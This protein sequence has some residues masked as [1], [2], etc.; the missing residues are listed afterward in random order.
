V[1]KVA[2]LRRCTMSA[3]GKNLFRVALAVLFLIAA[4]LACCPA[5]EAKAISVTINSPT[6]W[7]TV[8]VGQEVLIDSTVTAAVGVSRVDLSVDGRVV[9]QDVPPEGNPTTFR[10]VQPWAPASE[11][12]ATITVAAYDTQGTSGQAMITLQVVAS[13]AVVPTAGPGS[14]GTAEPTE[15]PPPPVTTEAGCTLDSQYVADV[16]VPDGTVMS[17]GAGFVK[18]WRVRNSGTCDWEAG[19]QLVFVS[20]EQMGGPASVTLP[21][22]AVGDEIDVSVNLLAPSIFGTHK[23]TWRVRAVGGT[24]FGSNL[25]VVI[26]VVS[27]ATETPAVVTTPTLAPTVAAPV[28]T[29]VPVKPLPSTAPYTERVTRETTLAGNSHDSLTV[30]CP[31]GTVVVGGGFSASPDVV[32]SAQYP[33]ITGWCANVGNT[34]GSSKV[35]RV[36]AV[37]LHNAPGASVEIV[38]ENTVMPSKG[39]AE[40]HAK[41]PAGSVVTGGGWKTT[42]ADVRFT[43][44]AKTGAAWNIRAY[45]HTSATSMLYA[46]AV[47]LSGTGGKTSRAEAYTEVDYHWGPKQVAVACPQ[48]TIMTGGGYHDRS[49]C[50]IL[51]YINAGPWG[52][53]PDAEWRVYAVNDV[54]VTLIPDLD[55]YAVCLQVP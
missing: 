15:T 42:G 2:F 29:T 7:S 37:C 41:C 22:G 45:N 33:Q 25:T 39:Y 55:V 27:P 21:A 36:Y 26:T 8:A 32:V 16:T 10:V 43:Q 12:Q 35:V 17:P 54:G 23:G 38:D 24:L 50:E 20:G 14:A 44:S 48:G 30:E 9:R 49:G 11:G 47:C 3:K 18:T 46:Y 51:V 4:V 19:S 1:Q 40:V 13:G 6:D 28:P 52:T 31:A 53:A 5:P 34:S